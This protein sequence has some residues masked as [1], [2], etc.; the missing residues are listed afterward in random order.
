MWAEDTKDIENGTNDVVDFISG[1]VRTDKANISFNGAWAQNIKCNEMFI[2]FLGDKGG[3]RLDYGGRFKFLNADT[4]EEEAPEY[5]M[6]SMFVK[7]NQAFIDS[8][9]SGEKPINYIDSVLESMKL[10]DALY[11]SSDASKEIDMQ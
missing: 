6:P 3:A 9:A 7:E 2:D 4:L 8:V 10:L 1:Y 11:K 5:D